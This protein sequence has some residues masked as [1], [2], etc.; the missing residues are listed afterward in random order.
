MVAK[1]S[2]IPQIVNADR[3]AIIKDPGTLVYNTETDRL[4]VV[5]NAEAFVPVN[6]GGDIPDN[7]IKQQLWV[8]FDDG[9]D[10]NDGGEYTPFKTYAAACAH[11]ALTA[12]PTNRFLIRIIGDLASTSPQLYPFIDLIFTNGTWTV[13]GGLDLHASWDN[14]VNNEMV[15]IQGMKMV[16]FWV[17]NWIGN[18]G[19]VIR[20]LNCDHGAITTGNCVSNSPAVNGVQIINDTSFAATSYS[21]NL[22]LTQSPSVLF[23]ATVAGE[24][25]YDLLQN[26]YTVDHFL[27]N[28]NIPFG[29]ILKK[30]SPNTS[31]QNVYVRNTPQPVDSPVLEDEDSNVYI[32]VD[33]YLNTPTFFAS[34]SYANIITQCVNSNPQLIYI[35]QSVGNDL[36]NGSINAPMKTYE[37]ARLAAV[38]RGAAEGYAVTIIVIGNQDITGDM[39]L[40]PNV[41]IRSYGA[42]YNGGFNVS[43]S[44]VI[45]AAWGSAPSYAE[46]SDLY[47]YV[48]GEYDL[49]FP[50]F[51]TFAWLKFKNCALNDSTD[52]IIQGSST[53]AGAETVT[54]ENCSADIIGYS[55]NFITDNINLYLINTDLSNS[56][57]ELRANVATALEYNLVVNNPRFSV[58]NITVL[59]S[60]TGTIKASILAANTNG[61]TL[62]IDGTGNTVLVDSTSYMF[63]LALANGATLS[64]LVLPTKTDGMTN[65]SYTP[66]NYT[67]AA[68]A[69]FSANTLTGNLK[70][71]DDALGTKENSLAYV[72]T[73]NLTQIAQV[74]TEYTA[75]N[76]LVVSLTLP[77]NASVGDTIRVNGKGAGGW[78]IDQQNAGHVIHVGPSS[79]TVG[80]TGSV[81]SATQYAS[82]TLRCIT[83]NDV[84][85]AIATSGAVT[86]YTIV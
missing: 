8:N 24:I 57:V 25:R 52:F 50:A 21:G 4:E 81:G 9:Q 30:T 1:S 68:E 6:S 23:N 14:V 2:K 55:P 22:F 69:D 56:N 77:I 82:I 75:N 39:T 40:S 32:D 31:T 41:Y 74:N 63:T 11:A 79:S 76:A 27:L 58:K 47:I 59:T 20:F 85:V 35:N 19:N 45:D 10:T 51:D 26:G 61:S 7:V 17:F 54:F 3:A 67:P 46:I 62:T 53:V 37:A 33:S 16:G 42:Q 13:T 86:A 36:N 78:R 28:S 71:I 84:W 80:P 15:T 29:I 18:N 73:S 38:A 64:D 44:V 72:E 60:S 49:V 48:G 66:V 43:G 83:A 70:G 65:S 34:G 5:D 12:S